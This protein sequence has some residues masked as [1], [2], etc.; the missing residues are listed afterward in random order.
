[1]EVKEEE[2]MQDKKQESS[3]KTLDE[4]YFWVT[5]NVLISTKLFVIVPSS[6]LSCS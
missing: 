2:M 4:F 6:T 5:S 1:M 3:E